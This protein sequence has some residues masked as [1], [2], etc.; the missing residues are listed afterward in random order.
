VLNKNSVTSTISS[1]PLGITAIG[2]PFINANTAAAG[3]FL[4]A[5]PNVTPGTA[6]DVGS[7]TG[8]STSQLW[9]AEINLLF[10][11]YRDEFWTWNAMIGFRH[12][13]L[14]EVI[15]VNSTSTQGPAGSPPYFFLGAALAPGQIETISDRFGTQNRFYGGNLGTEVEYRYHRITIDVRNDAAIGSM[16][17]TV[18]IVGT[19]TATTAAGVP[20][21]GS[22]AN[23]GLLALPTNIGGRIQNNFSVV[24][25]PGI[26]VG[27]QFTRGL[28]FAVGY[29]F[30]YAFNVARPGLQIDPGINPNL[31]PSSATFGAPGGT[32]RPA[33]LFAL[34]D[35]WAQGVNFSLTARY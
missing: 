14:A 8:F 1:G 4:V 27:Y 5:A 35:Y 10:N 33:P 13:D 17:S 6:G 24:E 2:R 34:T 26:L 22:P 15:Q 31:Q 28:K 16:R 23:G 12:F 3:T 19:T 30:I 20:L 29:D 25:Q 11:L 21:A 9:T 18:D 7:A 32:A